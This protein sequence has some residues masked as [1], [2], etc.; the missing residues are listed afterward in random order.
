MHHWAPGTDFSVEDTGDGVLLRP[1]K[2]GRPSG[3]T[4]SSAACGSKVLPGRWRRWTPPS[5]PNCGTVVIA[6]D[7]NVIIRLLTDD[8]PRQTEQARRLFE[9]ETIFLPKT[10]LLEAEWVLAAPIPP[11]AHHRSPRHWMGLVV[12][13]ECTVRGRTQPSVRPW[14]GTARHG[15][16][17]RAASGLQPNGRPVRNVR[18]RQTDQK[19]EHDQ[20]RRPSR[21]LAVSE[22]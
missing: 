10:V 4:T 18:P 8:E 1:I 9:T 11:G 3:W 5:T 21:D 22:P 6:A 14:T 12:A 15:L 2:T 17:R 19:L 20:D 7:T 16:C 13:A